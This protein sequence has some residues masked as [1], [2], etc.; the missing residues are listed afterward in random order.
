[1]MMFY[2]IFLSRCNRRLFIK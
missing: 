1:M 2:I